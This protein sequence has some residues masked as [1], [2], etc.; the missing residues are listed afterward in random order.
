MLVIALIVGAVGFAWRI[1][2][3]M[4]VRTGQP[5]PL[6]PGPRTRA[7][8]IGRLLGETFLFRSLL[9]ADRLAWALSWTFHVSLALVLFRHLWLILDAPGAFV[10]WGLKVVFGLGMWPAVAFVISGLGLLA[11]RALIARIRYISVPSDYGWLALLVGLGLTGIAMGHFGAANLAEA[12][13]FVHGF[14]RA[15]IEPLPTDWVFVLHVLAA[16]VVVGGFAFGKLFHG[17]AVWL[18]PTW[19]TRER[20]KK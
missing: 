16:G 9:R 3:V 6:T 15:T 1:V 19:N 10:G 11:R 17:G 14:V 20:P 8:V 5:I 4:R 18:S 2:Q 7:G 12:R 13:A